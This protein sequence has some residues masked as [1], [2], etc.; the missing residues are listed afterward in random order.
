MR[1]WIDVPADSPYPLQNLPYGSFDPPAGREH[2]G[3]RIGDHVVDLW[4]LCEADLI[5]LPFNPF[6]G[7]LNYFAALGPP[8]WRVTRN[9]LSRLLHIDEPRLRDDAELRA[10]AVIPI[11]RVT[12]RLPVNVGDY[13]DFYS[14]R[15]HATN[16]GA[17]FRPDNP[18]MPN[19]LHLPV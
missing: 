19:W 8:T 12:M 3:V 7:D 17:M 16:V 11:E 18:L 5:T 4:E 9:T 13:T 6:E 10:R 1:S 2:C 15:E 14:S